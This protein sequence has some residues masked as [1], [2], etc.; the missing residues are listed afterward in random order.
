MNEF[1]LMIVGLFSENYYTK[2][3]TTTKR[4]MGAFEFDRVV[5]AKNL[6]APGF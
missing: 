1:V 2:E 5:E 3:L 6:Y 4:E